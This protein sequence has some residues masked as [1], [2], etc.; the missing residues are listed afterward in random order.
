[1]IRV[2]APATDPEIIQLETEGPM[3][4]QWL[5][6]VAEQEAAEAARKAAEL[7]GDLH[8]PPEAHAA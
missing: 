6:R 7:Q 5:A 1:M 4:P 2:E 8:Q 3:S